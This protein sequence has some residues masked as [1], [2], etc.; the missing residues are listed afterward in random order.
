M[1]VERRRGSRIN[2]WIGPMISVLSVA[3]I[4]GMYV[5][6]IEHH[7]DQITSMQ[8]RYMALALTQAALVERDVALTDSLKDIKDELIRIREALEK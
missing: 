7:E 1:Q 2:G 6:D 8:D 3:V 4:L 5:A